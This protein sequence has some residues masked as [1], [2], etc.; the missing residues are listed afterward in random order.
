MPLAYSI[1]AA[2]FT[3]SRLKAAQGFIL[4]HIRT[5]YRLFRNAAGDFLPP[6]SEGQ[7]K[8]P[9]VILLRQKKMGGGLPSRLS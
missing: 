4:R 3:P 5:L 8:S 1:T 7:K 2:M 9:A 6:H